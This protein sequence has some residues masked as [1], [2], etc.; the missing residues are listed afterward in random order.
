M[1]TTAPPQPKPQPT[2]LSDA[3]RARVK[4]AW[5]ALCV[6]N[7][8]VLHQDDLLQV[9][10]KSEYQGNQGRLV[11]YY[12][13]LTNSPIVAFATSFTS[14]PQLAVQPGVLPAAIIGPRAQMQQPVHVACSGEFSDIATFTV[15][16]T[17][18]PR[19]TMTIELP[20]PVILSN[21]VSPPPQRQVAA[22]EFVAQW[23]TL[24]APGQE[25][26]QIFRS[27]ANPINVPALRSLFADGF[28]MAVL[29][30][31][32]PKETN[33]VLSGVLHVAPGRDIPVLVRLETNAEALMYRMTVRTDSPAA[34]ST[35]ASIIMSQIGSS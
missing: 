30:R 9:G 21:F 24:S 35:M 20:L 3:M 18:Q 25:L 26:Q 22:P 13:N 33:L 32:D 15:T 12:G 5:L 1:A 28:R 27:K 34:T 7:E 8:G 2:P 11:L 19:G 16:Y 4:A 31:V 23:K 10:V 17:Q 29:D 14:L 6:T